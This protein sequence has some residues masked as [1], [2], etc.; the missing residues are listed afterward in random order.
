MHLPKAELISST[1]L[2]F[3]SFFSLAMDRPV[4]FEAVGKW[5][6]HFC[7]SLI[8]KDVNGFHP[9]SVTAK[10]QF[11]NQIKYLAVK[12]LSLFVLVKCTFKLSVERKI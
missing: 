3:F 12:V 5:N 11:Q 8:E 4:S 2:S 1:A 7:I 10:P 9:S 6:K